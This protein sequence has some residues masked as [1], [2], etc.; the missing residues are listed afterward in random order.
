MRVKVY[1][2]LLLQS[3]NKTDRVDGRAPP[4]QSAWAPTPVPKPA[5]IGVLDSPTEVRY[6]FSH[7]LEL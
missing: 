4:K 3:G 7:P 5:P 1:V 2:F 6:S